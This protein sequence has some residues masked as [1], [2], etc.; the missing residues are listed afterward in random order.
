MFLASQL[1]SEISKHPWQAAPWSM[2]SSSARSGSW[3]AQ[4]GSPE[5]RRSRSS[6]D[7]STRAKRC[8]TSTRPPRPARSSTWPPGQEIPLYRQFADLAVEL[9][10]LPLARLLALAR[11]ARAPCEQARHI[12]HHQL[13]PAVNLVRVHPVPLGQLRNRRI[14][15]Q[16]HLRLERRIKLLA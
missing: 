3:S 12:L 14:L 5:H 6:A 10:R 2:R 9:G 4:T 1:V 11:H 7:A 15:P 8:V 16:R 13:L